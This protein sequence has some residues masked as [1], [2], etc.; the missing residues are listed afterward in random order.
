MAESDGLKKLKSDRIRIISK[1][2]LDLIETKEIPV[3]IKS[4]NGL[5]TIASVQSNLNELKKY[6]VIHTFR[7]NYDKMIVLANSYEL[8]RLNNFDYRF[9]DDN[10]PH[11]YLL[12]SDGKEH[13]IQF[14]EQNLFTIFF[15]QIKYFDIT[16]KYPVRIVP[17]VTDSCLEC[18]GIFTLNS[19]QHKVCFKCNNIKLSAVLGK[20]NDNVKKIKKMKNSLQKNNSTIYI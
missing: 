8:V 19:L 7:K 3:L 14:E 6:K 18:N 20:G 1:D 4:I 11:S 10:M 15:K 16:N 13:N 9:C 2:T 12:I 17:N 5:K